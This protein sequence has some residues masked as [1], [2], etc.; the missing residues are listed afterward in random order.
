MATTSKY[1]VINNTSL[2]NANFIDFDLRYG[3]LTTVGESIQL[4]GS[5]RRDA[6]FV[7][8]GLTYDLSNTAGAN[9]KIYFTG[10]L[11]DYALQVDSLNS[12]LT[13]TRT[14]PNESVKV[15]KGTPAAFDSLIF[16][17]GMVNT[18]AL[19]N[20][21]VSSVTLTPDA[22][23]ETSLAPLATSGA[24]TSAVLNATNLAGGV[25]RAPKPATSSFRCA[26]P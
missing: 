14:S 13:L 17:N 25:I 18:F 24:G 22:S 4:N 2:D 19:F 26:G 12:T 9:D 11:S 15:S 3:A 6:I 5:P 1:F 16:A 21:V 10:N 23:V 8:P 20:A 7:R